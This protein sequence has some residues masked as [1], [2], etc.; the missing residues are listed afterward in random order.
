MYR[1]W[2]GAYRDPSSPEFAAATAAIEAREPLTVDILDGDFERGQ[3]VISRFTLLPRSD[4]GWLPAVGR[5]W[6][7]DRTDPR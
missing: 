7:L 3:R 2:Q 4:E 6:N 5:H 1:F